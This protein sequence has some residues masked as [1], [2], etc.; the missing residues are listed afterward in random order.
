MKD[1][2]KLIKETEKMIGEK[3]NENCIK[4]TQLE[5]KIRELN[6]KTKKLEENENCQKCEYLFRL[7]AEKNSAE[8][9]LALCKDKAKFLKLKKQ[10]FQNISKRLK[11]IINAAKKYNENYAEEYFPT[12]FYKSLDNLSQIQ[13]E[14]DPNTYFFTQDLGDL[15]NCSESFQDLDLIGN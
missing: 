1:V 14:I 4:I 7:Q 15:G 10:K 2:Q 13:E 11:I 5:I 9:V 8:A 12:N 6:K 3:V